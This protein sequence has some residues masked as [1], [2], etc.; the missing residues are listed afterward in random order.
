[1]LN[2]ASLCSGKISLF[3]WYSDFISVS[4]NHAKW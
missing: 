4:F 2:R 1:M 3:F